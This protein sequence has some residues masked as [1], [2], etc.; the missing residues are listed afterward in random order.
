[1]NEDVKRTIELYSDKN[2]YAPRSTADWMIDRLNNN[3]KVKTNLKS[4]I[5][6]RIVNIKLLS[7]GVEDDEADFPMHL[8]EWTSESGLEGLVIVGF[9]LESYTDDTYV[10][11]IGTNKSQ[12]FREFKKLVGN[13]YTKVASSRS[14]SNLSTRLAD[15]N[16]RI[17]RLERR[18]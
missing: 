3:R 12:I 16:K 18:R 7:A 2:Y 10:T 15:L 14:A 5:H 11:D 4:V 9:D 8:L 17:A 1:M 6:D 13:S